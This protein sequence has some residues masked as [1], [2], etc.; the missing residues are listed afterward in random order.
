MVE[1]PIW[2]CNS[3]G[4]QGSYDSIGVY[5][6]YR[7]VSHPKGPGQTEWTAQVTPPPLPSVSPPLV[8]TAAH[9]LK[10]LLVLSRSL[11]LHSH[12]RERVSSP[13]RCL[14]ATLWLLLT[15]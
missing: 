11:F 3:G 5:I 15:T 14:N 4:L 1:V 13:Y 7:M 12:V 2:G 9:V 8:T 6:P 10:S